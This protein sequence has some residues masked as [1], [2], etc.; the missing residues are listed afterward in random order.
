[1][2]LAS[3]HW[4]KNDVFGE[5]PRSRHGHALAVAG[6]IV[7]M[8][9]GCAKS[10]SRNKEPTYFNDFY[11]LTITP[12]DSTWE[13]IPQTGHIPSPREGHN[14]CVVKKKIYLFGGYSDQNARECLPGVY[15]FDLA[16]LSW[17]KIKTNGSSPVTLHHSVVAIGENI[18]VFGGI[19]HGSVT[20]DL[21]MFSTGNS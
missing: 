17:E 7:F 15:S 5:P 4:V 13:V 8:F 14:I 20:D 1:M 16:T 12:N 3:G 10:S 11:M 9:G 2:A 21:L 18:F 19:Y 6:N